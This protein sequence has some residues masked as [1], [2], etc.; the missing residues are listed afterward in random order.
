[1]RANKRIS[2][3]IV[4]GIKMFIANFVNNIKLFVNYIIIIIIN[5]RKGAIIISMADSRKTRSGKPLAPAQTP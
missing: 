1:M 4:S 5:Y 2:E 3:L